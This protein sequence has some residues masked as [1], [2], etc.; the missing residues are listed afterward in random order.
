MINDRQL[1][2]MS[3]DVWDFNLSRETVS[4]SNPKPNRIE[5]YYVQNDKPMLIQSTTVVVL[6]IL[7]RILK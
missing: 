2:Q 1:I 7:V 5:I 4:V 6:L 3:F